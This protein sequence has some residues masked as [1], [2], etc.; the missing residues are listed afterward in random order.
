MNERE[1]REFRTRFEI[2]IDEDEVVE[3]PFYRPKKNSVE[4]M[5]I[6]KKTK[7]DGGNV[8]GEKARDRD[9]KNTKTKLF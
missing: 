1:L 4:M 9:V 5:Y 2:P 3:A 8:T 6:K 7:R